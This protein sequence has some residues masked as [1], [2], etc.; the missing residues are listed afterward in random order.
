MTGDASALNL[1]L[2]GDPELFA[3]VELS[4]L[5]SLAAVLLAA[6]IGV[7][8]GALLALT[9]FPSVRLQPLGHPSKLIRLTT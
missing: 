1:L 5:V 2:S 6:L 8:L 3:I 7:P 9:R 4:L